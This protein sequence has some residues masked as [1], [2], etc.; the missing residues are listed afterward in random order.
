MKIFSMRA[1]GLA[2][3]KLVSGFTL[4]AANA[5]APSSTTENSSGP[6]PS[7]LLAGVGPWEAFSD[8]LLADPVLVPCP[9]FS[10][11]FAGQLCGCHGVCKVNTHLD[12][13]FS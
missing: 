2:L 1:N 11:N 9:T 5:S 8:L 7:S 12:L 6:S 4:G 10:S 3:L 13:S